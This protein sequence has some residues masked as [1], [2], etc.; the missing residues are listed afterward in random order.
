MGPAH[1]LCMEQ[2]A[3]IDSYKKALFSVYVLLW[4]E[5]VYSKITVSV[6]A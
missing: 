1:F 2:H 3:M 5:M 4:N 6:T